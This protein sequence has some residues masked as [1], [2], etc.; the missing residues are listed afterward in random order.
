MK[1]NLIDKDDFNSESDYREAIE[2]FVSM[3]KVLKPFKETKIAKGETRIHY[4]LSAQYNDRDKWKQLL[5]YVTIEANPIQGH[6]HHTKI[7]YQD[8]QPE[9]VLHFGGMVTGSLD[10]SLNNLY[11]YIS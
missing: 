1:F 2:K 10:K 6:L 4:E 3:I 8:L 5:L 9:N 7:L 11:T